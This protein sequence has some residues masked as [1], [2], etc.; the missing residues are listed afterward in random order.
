M[1]FTLSFPLF[2]LTFTI[3]AQSLPVSLRPE[4]KVEFVTNVK[5][6][7]ARV[8]K[9][10]VS[11]NIFYITSIGNV[12][13]IKNPESTPS[14]K[15]LYTT[16]DHGIAYLQ[17]MAFIDSAL[18][19][20]GNTMVD[21]TGNI[22]MIK[23]AILRTSGLRT[24]VNVATTDIYQQSYTWYDH[25]FSGL[26]PSPDHQFLYFSS[27]SRT[28]HGEI[29]SNN[30]MYPGMREIPL[31]SAIFRIPANSENLS[32]YNDETQLAPYL[33]ADGTRNSFDLA[34]DSE[35]RIFA[36]ENSGD[37]DDPDELNWIRQGKHY[38]FPWTM[39]GNNN[40]QQF[41]GYNPNT[42]PL[43]NT[44]SHCFIK[45]YYCDDPGFPPKGSLVTTP[46]VKN[47]GPDADKYREN[48]G[49]VNDGSSSGNYVTSFTPH[50]CPLGIS[51]DRAHYLNAEF[52]GHAFILSFTRK[53][54]STGIDQYG[55]PGTIC[56][57]G[58]DLMDITLQQASNGEFEMHAKTIVENFNYPV[59][60][61]LEGNIMYVI[62]YS[63]E[64]DG[65]LFRITLPA[66]PASVGNSQNALRCRISPNPCTDNLKIQLGGSTAGIHLHIY[67]HLG[68]V[69]HQ[70]EFFPTDGK[71]ELDIDLRGKPP[72]LYYVRAVS[73]DIIIS[74]KLVRN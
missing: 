15:L 44:K 30:G 72:G 60:S 2:M 10:P 67:D 45:G 64:G 69:V 54:D 61:Y 58:Q 8:A 31:T 48:T 46:P 16:S 3:S 39:G 18:F 68:K 38:G 11:G 49:K 21:S 22:G 34:F 19:L 26:T 17:G 74:E 73:G 7:A 12:Y 42:D 23:K 57:P 62:E 56:D 55:V 14:E 47:L 27:G 59:D 40:P 36:T 1:K 9:D 52:S 65:R 33:F 63:Y 41:A 13:E 50:R 70:Q 5:A 35:D 32:L 37:R 20:I 25:G 43:L 28:D 66:G 4:I 71:N 24:W 29:Q 51:I 53:G 6:K